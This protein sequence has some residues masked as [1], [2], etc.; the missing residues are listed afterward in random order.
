MIRSVRERLLI[1]AVTFLLATQAAGENP[2][3]PAPRDADGRFLNLAGPLL[4]AGPD[5][6]V[7]FLIRRLF[8]FSRRT[9]GLPELEPDATEKMKQRYQ[10]VLPRVTWIGHAS[11]LLHHDDVTYLTDPQWSKRAGPGGWLGP[12]RFQPPGIPLDELPPIDFVLISH[13]HYDHLDL[14]T[15]RALAERRAETVFLVPLSNG[16]LLRDAGVENVQELDWGETRSFG[17]ATVQCLPSQHWSSRGLTDERRALW[18][19]WSITG[20]ERRVYFAGD[21][22]LLPEFASIGAALG[23]FDLALLPIGAYEPVSMMRPVHLDPEEA[24]EAA[25]LLRA[26]RVLGIHFGTFNLTDEPIGEPPLR[27]RAAAEAAGRDSGSAWVLRI[28]QTR[29]F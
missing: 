21:T 1:A 26:E 17:P 11:L 25:R 20:A 22:G 8:G 3:G 6:T 23:P 19:S 14:P 16:A 27:F 29:N 18:S 2:F 12:A 5:V 7:P 28:G 15:L 10:G 24:I 13:N 4:R 9:E